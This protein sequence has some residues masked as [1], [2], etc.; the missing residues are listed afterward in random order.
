MGTEAR[1]KNKFIF[2]WVYTGINHVPQIEDSP[3]MSV[4]VI[5]L[6]FKPMYLFTKD[7]EMF[8]I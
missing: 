6:A 3:V 8:Q 5:H 7:A 2:V 4:E 1:F